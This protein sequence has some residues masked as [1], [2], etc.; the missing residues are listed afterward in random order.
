MILGL[1]RRASAPVIV[2][3]RSAD[4]VALAAI[5]ATGFERGWDAPEFERLLADPSVSCH[6]AR[7]GG[8]GRPVG[9]AMSRQVLDEAEVLTIAVAPA[10]RGRGLARALM[11]THLGRLAGRGVKTLFLEVADD[12]QPALRLYR[13]FGFEE[14]GRR[15]GYYARR[16][17]APASALIMRRPLG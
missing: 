14:V 16:G 11:A 13:G 17:K 2:E 15:A 4:A 1:F 5:H 6:A 12:N 7:P 10:Q 9:F 8:S 3:A